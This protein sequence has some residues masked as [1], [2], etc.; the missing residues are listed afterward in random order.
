MMGGLTSRPFYIHE[1]PT[2]IISFVKKYIHP[3]DSTQPP[4]L[5][6]PTLP[7][8]YAAHPPARGFP[9][10]M[11]MGCCLLVVRDLLLLLPPPSPQLPDFPRSETE[12]ATWVTRLG[13]RN[14]APV[15]SFNRSR[16]I[17][18]FSHSIE[19]PKRKRKKDPVCRNK[20]V[21]ARTYVTWIA[22]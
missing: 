5:P 21:S 19:P 1:P 2:V 10:N 16:V 17:P 12:T 11:M 8:P 7:P 22:C 14:K 13:T 15:A 20:K 18:L 6:Y 9:D 4:P 3:V